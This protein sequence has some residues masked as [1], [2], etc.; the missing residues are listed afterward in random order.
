[1]SS[2]FSTA[3]SIGFGLERLHPV[4]EAPS[5]DASIAMSMVPR[6]PVIT[7]TGVM[8]DFALIRWNVSSP[9]SPGGHTSEHH[10]V[11]GFAVEDLERGLA[12]GR[13]R[14]RVSMAA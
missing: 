6:V 8:G 5:F 10:H 9:L 2:A 11:V 14:D 4:I 1:V 3:A 7:I 12:R 13:T